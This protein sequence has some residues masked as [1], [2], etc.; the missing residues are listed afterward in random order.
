[1]FL[2]YTLNTKFNK[3]EMKDTKH[4][5][6][7]SDIDII[8]LVDFGP[9]GTR[10]VPA[11]ARKFWILARNFLVQDEKCSYKKLNENRLFLLNF[12]KQSIQFNG[13]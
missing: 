8:R 10:T 11:G 9:A 5:Q 6:E 3:S 7:S 13:Y 2:H 1:M 4:G 12:K